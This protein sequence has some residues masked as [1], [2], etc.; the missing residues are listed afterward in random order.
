MNRRI[1]STTTALAFITMFGVSAASAQQPQPSPTP[2]PVPEPRPEL[3]IARADT[4]KG[5]LVSVDARTKLITIKTD[6]G[7]TRD[8]RYTDDTK[9]SGAQRGIAGLA[10]TPAT[11]VTVKLTGM[12]SSQTASEIIVE[13]AKR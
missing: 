2:T 13:P 3:R 8:V 11:R 9:V 4:I 6:E 10:N 7:D 12:G 5:Q 1:I